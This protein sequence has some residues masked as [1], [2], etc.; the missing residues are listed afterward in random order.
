LKRQAIE[1]DLARHA[2]PIDPALDQAEALLEDFAGFWDEEPS[3]LGPA[4]KHR[5]QFF[6]SS[7][8]CGV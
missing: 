4:A 8:G 1:E 5:A 7:S 3:P 6:S 2:P